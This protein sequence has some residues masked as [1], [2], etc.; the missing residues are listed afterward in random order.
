MAD[1][2]I[3][4]VARALCIQRGREPDQ[5]ESGDDPRQNDTSVIDGHMPN[6]DAAHFSWREFEND[7]RAIITV[8]RSFT[9][10]MDLRLRNLDELD[11][12]C[13][14]YSPAEE[15]WQWAIDQALDGA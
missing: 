3:E 10:E 11:R 14:I 15:A 1:S 13:M 6:G 5:L 9:E 4:R 2:M 8:M 12:I 7:A